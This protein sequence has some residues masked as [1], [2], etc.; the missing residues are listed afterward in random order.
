MGLFKKQSGGFAGKLTALTFESKEWKSDTTGKG[1]STLT[2]KLVIEKDGADDS[3]EQYLPAGFFYPKDGQSISDDGE[4]LEGGAGVGE[5]SEFARFVQS[6][7]EKG[8]AE[9]DILD[10]DG[11]GTN[12]AAL[13]GY[14]YEFGREI[15]TERQLAAGAK[16]LGKVKAKT[17]T[18]EE[19][20][21]AG[22]Q[23]DKKDK[24]KFYNHSFLVVTD[25]FAKDEEA[26]KAKGAASKGKAAPVAKSKKT[27][28]P[29]EDEAEPDYAD[30][31]A[32]LLDLLAEAK[33]NTI[34][35]ASLSS[36]VV[37]KA[38]ADDLEPAVRDA[39]RK[40][41][42]DD[43]YLSRAEGWTFDGKV[44]VLAKKGKKR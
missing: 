37:R 22:R 32:V 44:V 11:N 27:A 28:E 21:K 19:L 34:A 5:N 39:L 40:T 10:D 9:E 29:E 42:S 15:N 2:A 4:T 3:I 30:A 38:A 33:N 36:L 35:Q 25:V 12:F 18:D 13:V 20:M 41:L 16:K 26:P 23:Q 14:R 6:A 7:V 8:I 43:D 24:S 1:Y 17:A 31:D